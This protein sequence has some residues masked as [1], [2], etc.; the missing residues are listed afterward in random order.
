MLLAA[1][2][3]MQLAAFIA[4]PIVL[5]SLCMDEPSIALPVAMDEPSIAHAVM[6]G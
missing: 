6:H 4:L 2:A 5:M 3:R 1:Y